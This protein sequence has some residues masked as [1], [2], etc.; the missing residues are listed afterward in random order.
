MNGADHLVHSLLAGGVDV[1]F[2][3]PGTSE[4]HFV[5]AL[6]RHA[7]M[8]C[9]LG[10]FEGV[11]TGAA[12]GY[13]R[14]A[15]RPAATLL[16]LGPGLGNGLANLHNARKARSGIVNVVGEHALDH[17]ALDAPLTADIEG[18]AR[19]VSHW[20]RTTQSA[21][22][23]GEDTR[24]AVAVASSMPGSIA[25]LVLPAD[26]AWT[27]LPSDF[28]LP[29]PGSRRPVRAPRALEAAAVADCARAVRAP[30]RTLLLLG[31]EA[32]SE[33]ALQ[34]AG[35]IGTATGCAVMTE[36][37]VARLARGAGRVIAPRLPYAVE[38]ALAALAPF[39]RVI[40]VG[41][42]EPVAFFAY[43]GKPGRL[44]PAGC[45]V[46]TL[47][48][49]DQDLPGALAALADALDARTVDPVHVAPRTRVG[50]SALPTGAPDSAGIAAV[51]TEFMPEQ[52]IV[53]DEA[54]SVG[55]AFGP[56]TVG[57]APHD[58]LAVMGGSIGF[59]LPAA[60]GAAV[61]APD[62]K[63]VALE[64]D[65]SALYTIQALWTMAREGLD[66]VVVILANRAY[67]ILRGE[68]A[69]VGAGAPGQ[70]ATD[71]LTLDRPTLDFVAIARGMGL[72]AG[73]AE[74]LGDFARLF[75]RACSQRGP[76]LIELVI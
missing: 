3:N 40:L 13:W 18:I 75:E 45:E 46:L 65:G 66:I 16:H 50:R 11:V 62:R 56:A 24:E 14:M 23:I 26:A 12:D 25:T 20:V 10:L 15:G 61:A 28:A 47:A 31:G 59:G 42:R 63:V 41:A 6:D 72:E 58:W 4:M 49:S 17:I 44:L 5:A 2:A 70:R 22:A 8:R 29:Q 33:P 30:G 34:A 53:I 38:P 27:D 1:C 19:P 51:L 76:A 37:Y 9:V 39:S 71:M 54:V 73:R 36:F 55:R 64:G 48:Q 74:D 35:R 52:A 69:G 68:F 60:V 43:P 67:Q 21:R 7:G 32:A 57:A